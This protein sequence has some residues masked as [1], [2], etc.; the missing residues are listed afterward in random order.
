S[1]TTTAINCPIGYTCAAN[2]GTSAPSTG[3]TVSSY[4]TFNRY[5]YEG[6]TAQGVSDPDVLQ[7][8]KRLAADGY[9][10]GPQTGY[11]GP[12]TKSAVQA[13]Q[14]AYG[15]DAIGVVGPSTRKLLNE[16]K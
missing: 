1:Q 16:G 12:L 6:M 13:F 11:F 10:S 4:Y 7:L 15:L 8:Q 2:G 3:S 9:F 14:R 5:L